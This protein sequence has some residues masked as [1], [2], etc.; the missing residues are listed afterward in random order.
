M[1]KEEMIRYF[2]TVLSDYSR[3]SFL[4][5]LI[6]GTGGNLSLRVPD[7]DTV[8]ITPT[9]VSLEEVTPECSVLVD[10]D[11][12]IIESPLGFKGSKE[13]GFHLSAY[14]I[15]ADVMA[16]A[17]LHPPYS[18]A[19]AGA[20]ASLPLATVSARLILKEVPCVPCYNPGSKELA[21]CVTAALQKNLNL[22]ALLM[23][24][25][26][27]LALGP[28]MKAAY[29]TADLVEHTAQVAYFLKNIK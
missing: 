26:G 29:Y 12:N 1:K 23:Q 3:R 19:Y 18:T 21:D 16:V 14:K 27:I 15:R 28:D 20:G 2:R 10:L 25:H 22:K 4:R 7:T 5:R 17:H 9:G 24:D 11:G 13:T 6:G 8:L